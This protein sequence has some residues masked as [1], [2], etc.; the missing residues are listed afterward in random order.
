MAIKIMKEDLTKITKDY[1]EKNTKKL[2][3]KIFRSLKQPKTK[4]PPWR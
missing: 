1:K 2:L 3:R 4:I